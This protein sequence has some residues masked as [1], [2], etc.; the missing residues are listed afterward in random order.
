MTVLNL[1][2]KEGK[3]LAEK[4]RSFLEKEGIKGSF[5]LI[6]DEEIKNGYIVLIYSNIKG[7]KNRAKKAVELDEKGKNLIKG[8]Y[9]RFIIHPA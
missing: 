5:K 6:K 4:I 2:K 1:D 3:H 9:I 8:K 7:E